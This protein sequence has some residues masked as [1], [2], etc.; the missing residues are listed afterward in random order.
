MPKFFLRK[1]STFIF[2]FQINQWF[3][4]IICTHVLV[5]DVTEVA[6][7]SVL[8]RN[9]AT[10][11]EIQQLI[12]AIETSNQLN[13]QRMQEM[14]QTIA[15]VVAHTMAIQNA[16]MNERFDRLIGQQNGQNGNWVAPNGVPV[17][18]PQAEAQPNIFGINSP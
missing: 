3:S 13:H 16:Q 2:N 11:L 15:Q 18:G 9:K 17:I 5:E 6:R 7:G 12:R 14:A 4:N 10:S 8:R 1:K